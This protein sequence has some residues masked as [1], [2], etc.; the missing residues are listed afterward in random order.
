M[1]SP[2]IF[3]PYSSSTIAIM[4]NACMDD[5]SSKSL[6]VVSEVKALASVSS[7]CDAKFST[8]LFNS[9]YIYFKR[10]YDL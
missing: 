6:K 2:L 10:F 4:D 3:T 9:I 8:N 5:H 7:N 1:S